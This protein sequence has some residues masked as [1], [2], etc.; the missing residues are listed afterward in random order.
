MR[1]QPDLPGLSA[2]ALRVLRADQASDRE[3]HSAYQRFAGRPQQR[4]P[5]LLVSRWLLA[6]LVMG[7]GMAFAADAVVQR[8][9]APSPAEQPALVAVP[10][11]ARKT[12]PLNAPL[13]SLQQDPP[14]PSAEPLPSLSE[15]KP[16]RAPSVSPKPSAVGS[17]ERP[18][19]D[20][21]VW[22]K[23]AQGLRDKDFAQTAAALSTLEHA[24][25]TT[26][27]EAA[28]LIRAQL[29]LHQ[30]NVSGARAVLQELLER[31]QSAQVRAKAQGLLSESAAKSN[32]A[33]NVAPSGT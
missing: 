17:D 22:A 30:G 14:E 15:S 27:R 32:P 23:A 33:L 4:A 24:G 13:P 11:V 19:A 6:G 20:G 25:S 7:L 29:M 28:R 21:A 5:G 16:A 12:A 31:A 26:D 9:K 8:R 1:N 3:L 10:G 18:P 2:A